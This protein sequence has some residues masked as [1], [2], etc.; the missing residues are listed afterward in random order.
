MFPSI[1]RTCLGLPTG[2]PK[3][4]SEQGHKRTHWRINALASSAL[5]CRRYRASP[6]CPPAVPKGRHASHTGLCGFLA[7]EPG[8]QG[9]KGVRL[10]DAGLAG[11]YNLALDARASCVRIAARHQY[12][13]RE[14]SSVGG[15]GRL[16]DSALVKTGLSGRVCGFRR[17]C[18]WH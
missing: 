15:G 3:D 13:S 14:S 8:N 4:G 9:G 1:C 18:A 17:A 10:F 12:G 5:L 11:F 16:A 2:Q 7:T 6:V